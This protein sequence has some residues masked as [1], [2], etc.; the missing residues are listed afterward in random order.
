MEANLDERAS[1]GAEKQE[2]CFKLQF[3]SGGG[4][5][6]PPPIMHFPKFAPPF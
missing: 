3:F 6:D 1:G 2:I 4:P 5:P